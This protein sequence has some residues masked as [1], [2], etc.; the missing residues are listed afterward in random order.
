MWLTAE[1]QSEAKGGR[2]TPSSAYPSLADYE[3]IYS[4]PSNSRQ[5][6]TKQKLS[7]QVAVVSGNHHYQF[8][9]APA[10][11]RQGL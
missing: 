11:L 3:L 4:D 10:V 1:L 6:H 2:E 8:G 5:T 9:L 7:N